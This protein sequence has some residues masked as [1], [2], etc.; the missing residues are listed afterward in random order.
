MKDWNIYNH[1]IEGGS[2]DTGEAFSGEW[3]YLHIYFVDEDN[4]VDYPFAIPP[5]LAEEICRAASIPWENK[6]GIRSIGFQA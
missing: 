1:A 5:Q 4:M 6:T 3:P 2:L